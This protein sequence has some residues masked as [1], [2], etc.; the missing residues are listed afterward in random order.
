MAFHGK[1]IESL[2]GFTLKLS[3]RMEGFGK[4]K[5]IVVVDDEDIFGR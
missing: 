3:C 1:V 5:R 2:Y 4:Q